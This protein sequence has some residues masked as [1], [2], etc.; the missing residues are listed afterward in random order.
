MV[1]YSIA[2]FFI[3]TEDHILYIGGNAGRDTFE[4][5]YLSTVEFKSICS[6]KMC[7]IRSLDEGLIYHASVVT[8][9]GVITCGG[10]TPKGGRN[11]CTRLTNINTWEPFP[12]L[13]K[14]RRLASSYQIL[15][16]VVVGDTVVAFETYSR[17]FEK[18]NWN[19]GE[20]WELVKMNQEFYGP[21][22]VNWDDENILIIGG[23]SNKSKWP[24][25]VSKYQ[26]QSSPI[27]HHYM[28]VF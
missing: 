20:K 14:V 5:Y 9:I 3:F 17:T 27:I 24:Y 8:P 21:C 1:F 25:R 26:Q 15:H 2:C 22:V 16:M 28:S 7:P 10:A 19:T 6:N 11:E 13:N 12:S 23:H 4:R 18:I